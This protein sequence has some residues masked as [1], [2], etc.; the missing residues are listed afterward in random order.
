MEMQ[1]L[2]DG[3]SSAF[4]VTDLLRGVCYFVA[5]KG[6]HYEIE[7]PT[8]T[9]SV[10]VAVSP[11]ID[12]VDVADELIWLL[13]AAKSVCLTPNASAESPSGI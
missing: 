4:L 9:G 13:D 7:V 12:V 3:S 8:K 5:D 6:S 10:R 11:E 2:R 1:I